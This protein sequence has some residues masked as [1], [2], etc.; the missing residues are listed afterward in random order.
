MGY[1]L[2]T[3]GDLLFTGSDSKNIRVWKN[4]I[5]FS[6]LKSK[7]VWL[8]LWFLQQTRYSPDIETGRS[9]FGKSRLKTRAF[10]VWQVNQN[11]SRL[12][13]D[14]RVTIGGKELKSAQGL[15]F[16]GNPRSQSQASHR[17]ASGVTVWCLLC[18]AT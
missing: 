12:R 13:P 1:S 16:D 11:G 17:I 2:A 14:F 5:E 18:L 3:S 8:K 7:A 6:T 4:H 9:V 10:S 15:Y